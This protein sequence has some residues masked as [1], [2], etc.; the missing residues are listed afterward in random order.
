MIN[1]LPPLEKAKR[2]Q[3]MTLKIVWNIGIVLFASFI[4]FMFM[5]LSVKFYLDNQIII[6]KAL[7]DYEKERSTQV[8]ELKGRVNNINNTLNELNI[9]YEDQFLST[10]LLEQIET[11]IPGGIYLD[12]YLYQSKQSLV[13]ISGYSN[14]VETVY[15]L[16][17]NLREVELFNDIQLTISDWLQTEAINFRVTFNLDNEL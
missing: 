12:T 11:Y 17:E 16:R 7:I 8:Q 6:Q 1:L 3:E 5:I 2:R 14:K 15:Q 10:E 13:S 4:A 9:F